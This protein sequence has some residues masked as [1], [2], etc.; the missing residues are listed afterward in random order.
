MERAW[1]HQGDG[2]AETDP[3]GLLALLAAPEPPVAWVHVD[4]LDLLA[5]AARQAGVP[6]SV[7]HRAVADHGPAAPGDPRRPQLRRLPGGGRYLVSPTLAYDGRTRDVT[8]GVWGSLE[9]E[10]VTITAEEGPG[11]LL[12]DVREHLAE[13]D[14]LPQDRESHVFAAVLMALV[15]RAGDVEMGIGEAVADVEQL[16]FSPQADDPA[17]V[18]YDLKREIGEARR[19]LVPLLS[20][21]PDLVAEQEDAQRETRT[22]RWLRRLDTVLTKV[23]RHLDAH[24]ALLGD[25]LS[26]HLSRV[27]VRQNEDMRKIS[28]WAA[29]IAVP[30]LIAGVY[31]MNFDHMPELHWLVGYPASIVLMGAAAGL[32]FRLFKRSG[33]L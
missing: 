29:I 4:S 16:V 14:H 25:M 31:G 13:G 8:T 11:A 15:R 19:A 1:V 5:D 28:A 2:W 26:V 22:M 18:V 33:W 27:S 17:E 6:E 9:V 10:G 32:L 24:D 23:D 7:V 12:D 30:T 21:F 3:D 20:A